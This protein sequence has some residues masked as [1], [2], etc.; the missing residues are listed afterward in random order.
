MQV[1]YRA[2]TPNIPLQIDGIVSVHYF[3]YT[4]DF[5]YDGESHDFWE[6]VYCDKGPL[7]ITAGER[8]IT[9]ETR[10]LYLHPPMQFHN[11]RTDGTHSAS[12][13]IVSFTCKLQ[14]L[15]RIADRVIEADGY[16]RSALFSILREA[17]FSFDN[18]LGQLYD[19]SLVRRSDNVVFASEQVLLRELEL[20]LIHLV[21]GKS[22]ADEV[23]APPGTGEDDKLAPILGYLEANVRRRLSVGE[24]SRRFSISPTTLKKLFA[25][26]LGCGVMAYF[27]DC[28]IREAK[29]LIRE[30]EKNFSEIALELG[31]ASVHHFSRIFKQKTGMTPTEYGRS[32]RAMLEAAS[33]S[34]GDD[35]SIR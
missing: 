24:V 29:K 9:L 1:N 26:H 5:R 11:I 6:L 31:F 14:G 28:R 22:F 10:E 4:G 13:V 19:E 2:L 27:L 8:E 20:L 21:R 17:K 7:V 12:S 35:F 3:E 16:L 30:Q 15:W 33:P 32:V 18:R 25:T 23:I 34:E